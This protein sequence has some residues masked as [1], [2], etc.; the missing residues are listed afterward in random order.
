[1]EGVD[2]SAKEKVGAA[3]S[4]NTIRVYRSAW[5]KWVS[6]AAEKGVPH[7]PAKPADIINY[8][9]FLAEA[10]KSLASLRQSLASISKAHKVA[11][12][13]SPTDSEALGLFMRGVARQI[14][15]PAAQA[16]A[17]DDH[18]LSAIEAT[19]LMPRTTRGG[20][21][22][23]KDV[24]KARGM[25]DIAIARVLSDAGLR[26][27]EAVALNWEDIR[28]DE[29]GGVVLVKRSK[30]DPAGVGQVVW[31]GRKAV[32]AL[33][34]IRPAECRPQDP[35]FVSSQRSRNGVKGKYRMSP[36]QLSRRIA[37][38]A[39][40]A[41]LGDRYSG[42]SGRVGMV[43][44]TTRSGAPVDAIMKQGRWASPDMVALYGREES[45]A[46]ILQYL[47]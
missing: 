24:A 19:A 36:R 46:R 34:R 45:G 11:G 26:R 41:G 37:K 4:P 21:V 35:V 9:D 12:H 28:E 6:H 22:E 23:D 43:V 38:A 7:L 5:N 44:R 47:E 33:K 42:H 32:E 8:L 17:L 14:G 20:K 10:G 18:A 31:V 15:R 30:G 39:E 13:A 1:L 3:L 27:S 25:V 16:M 40:F 2:E 29:R